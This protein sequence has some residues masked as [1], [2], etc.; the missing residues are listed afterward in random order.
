[1][2]KTYKYVYIACS[3]LSIF[4]FLS[5]EILLHSYIR[6]AYDNMT[7]VRMYIAIFLITVS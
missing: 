2:Q 1:M 6:S 7:V 3:S 4:S 5:G